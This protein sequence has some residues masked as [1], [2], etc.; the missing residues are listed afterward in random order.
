MFHILNVSL[1]L[2]IVVFLQGVEDY[3]SASVTTVSAH[4]Y[5]I[6]Q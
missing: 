6:R 2:F 3:D 5:S 1:Y 4:F